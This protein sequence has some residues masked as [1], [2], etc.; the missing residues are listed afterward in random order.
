MADLPRTVCA[1]VAVSFDG[2]AAFDGPYD[3]VTP[4]VDGPTGLSL[5]MWRD[6]AQQLNPPKV[7]A[8][9]FTLLNDDGRYS[10]Y[11][12]DSPV[13]QRFL[14][15]RPVRYR[16]RHGDSGKTYRNGGSY[17]DSSY[18]RGSGVFDL[19][20]HLVD[21]LTE[22]LQWGD[23]RVAVRTLG[24]ETVLTR[25]PVTVPLM[26]NP[27]VD[28]CVSAIL[29]AAGWPSGDRAIS[30]SDT[31]LTYWW[32]DER[33]AWTAL[34][35]LLAAE[36]PGTFYVDSRDGTPVFHFESRNDRTIKPRS[37]TSQ[38]TYFDIGHGEGTPYRTSTAYRD[39][40]LYRGT[41]SG[42][43]YTDLVPSNPY[44]S[45][46]NRA[47]YT[48]RRRTT[49]TLQAVWD[50]GTTLTLAAGEV[51]TLYARPTEPFVNAVAPAAGTDYT[52]SAGSATV[53]LT[54]T[55]GFL[56]IIR[57]TAGGSGATVAG[58]SGS[59]GLRLR[60]QPLTV[61][62]ET[63]VANT[64]DASISIAT[65]SPIPGQNIPLTLSVA[66][67]PEI[68]PAMAEAVCDSWVLRYQRPRA[69]VTVTLVNADAAH[70]AEIFRLRPSD[71]I[72]LANR[73]LGL[74]VDFWVNSAVLTIAGAGGRVLT[75]T[76]GCE[77]CDDL[78]G[79]VWNAPDALWGTSPLDPLGA[80]WGV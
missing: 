6:G 16:V 22:T 41:T 15:A 52:V 76:L 68:D 47:T 25:A 35:E 14:P 45:I 53:A 17:R 48:T 3:V 28:Q 65:F 56:A 75:L 37:V 42:L 58:A 7:A 60:A 61:V 31:Q 69:Q 72:T 59:A 39:R 71:R 32:C 62:S 73:H 9:A 78:R 63:T 20:H 51:R 1:E 24:R 26:T 18:Y 64:V 80:V 34:T 46:Y 74:A 79:S 66:G 33:D 27:R 8:G 44:R 55:S 23:R 57:V 49:G 54:Y 70:L 50:Y 36:G 30:A 5:D 4:D 12:A 13:Y 2:S 10:P 77:R 21:E 38:A 11:R 43:F 19:G 67:W 29:D 40:K